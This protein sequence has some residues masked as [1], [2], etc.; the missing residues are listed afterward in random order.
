[1]CV[2]VQEDKYQGAAVR[3]TRHHAALNGLGS[4]AQ[5]MGGLTV[6]SVRVL[7]M[8]TT[9]GI[10]IFT[11]REYAGFSAFLP[12]GL[13]SALPTMFAGRVNSAKVPPGVAALFAQLHNLKGVRMDAPGPANV[14][15]FSE[16][17]FKSPAT[18]G[19]RFD[20]VRSIQ[21]TARCQ[22][23]CDKGTCVRP[24]K[25]SCHP[26][27]HG[28]AC[29]QPNADHHTSSVVCE[30]NDVFVGEETPC[31]ILPRSDGEPVETAGGFFDVQC[32]V[33]G[34]AGQQGAP[35]ASQRLCAVTKG[36]WAPATMYKQLNFNVSSNAAVDGASADDDAAQVTASTDV[37][38]MRLFDVQLTANRSAVLDHVPLFRTFLR[39]DATSSVSCDKTSLLIGER[40]HC[41]LLPRLAGRRIPTLTRAFVIGAG[42]GG[43]VSAVGVRGDKSGARV[44]GDVFT[45][46]YTAL[47]ASVKE[48]VIS[49]TALHDGR[50]GEGGGAQALDAPTIKH[51]SAPE[52]DSF[53][54]AK[55]SIF[56]RRFIDARRYLDAAVEKADQVGAH[57]C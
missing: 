45:F 43:R 57:Y 20:Q 52:S 23:A 55:Q 54:L 50:N 3:L 11:G 32:L 37:A 7:S 30:R 41:V 35:P 28:A 21:V 51:V 34:N 42:R 5:V 6:R 38:R 26:G 36:G 15:A 53:A 40:S 9:Q 19:H 31:S 22:P 27:W 39:P 12:L 4:Q 33:G 29:D 1:M 47:S 56:V 44:A 46:V 17:K 25:C 14:G 8:D 2:P 24:N 16:L 48:A 49:V 13:H 10:L 18:A